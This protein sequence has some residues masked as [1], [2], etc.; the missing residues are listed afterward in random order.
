MCVQFVPWIL[1]PLQAPLPEHLPLLRGD[2]GMLH[3]RLKELL[4]ALTEAVPRQLGSQ[5]CL[6]STPG[7]AQQRRHS[8]PAVLQSQAQ[9]RGREGDSAGPCRHV[10]SHAGGAEARAWQG[11]AQCRPSHNNPVNLP[12]TR[13]QAIGPASGCGRSTHHAARRADSTRAGTAAR[14]HPDQHR[15]TA[16]SSQDER[17]AL[18]SGSLITEAAEGEG[19]REVGDVA[20]T[21]GHAGHAGHAGQA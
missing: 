19:A 20:M 5:V 4:L 6:R 17:V 2:G 1:R 8:L 21:L 11:A 14:C 3:Q 16:P 12:G 10:C 9:H 15:T 7:N 13:T 18:R